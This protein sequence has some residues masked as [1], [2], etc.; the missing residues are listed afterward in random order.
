[1]TVPLVT[2]GLLSFNAENTIGRAI[3]SCLAQSWPNLEILIVDDASS[4]RT[5]QLARQRIEDD[6]RARVICHEQN[7]GAAGARNTVLRLARGEFIAFFDDDDESLPERTFEQVRSLTIYEQRT[8]Q[9]LVACYASGIRRYPNGYVKPMPA[10]GAKGGEPP[11]GPRVA[12]R[13]LFYRRTPGW[14]FGSGVPTCALLARRDTFAAVGGF[15]RALRRVEDAD[16]AIRLALLGGHF[17]GTESHVLIQNA[18][19]APD[20]SPERNLE[21]E[22]HLATKHADYLRTVGR[23]HYAWRWPR[24]RYWHFKR[25][26]DMVLCELVQLTLRNPI[27][28]WRHILTTGPRRLLHEIALR[29]TARV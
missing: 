23:Y 18:T 9:K 28:V 6:P 12:D 1:M 19:S 4:D 29:R 14:F 26:Y 22:Q 10:I 17:I 21:A 8:G 20:K 5:A 7:T 3:D 25:R 15:D 24:L 2:A 11:H 16:F 27:A 13:L